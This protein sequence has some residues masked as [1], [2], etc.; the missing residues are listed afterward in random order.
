MTY[1]KKAIDVH[2][3]VTVILKADKDEEAEHT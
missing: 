3:P 2:Q 1:L